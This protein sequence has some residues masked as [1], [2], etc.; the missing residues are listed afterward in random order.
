MG[1]LGEKLPSWPSAQRAIGEIVDR[2]AGKGLEKTI[3]GARRSVGMDLTAV[4]QD[5]LARERKKLRQI[6]TGDLSESYFRDQAEIIKMVSANTD[7]V[8]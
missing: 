3:L 1:V 7:M 4:P 6:A 5:A 2:R 8:R